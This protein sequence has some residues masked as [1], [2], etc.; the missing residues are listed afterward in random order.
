MNDDNA[1]VF[2]VACW[3]ASFWFTRGQEAAVQF[4]VGVAV[5]I[6]SGIL[7]NYL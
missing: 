1:L 3:L 7:Y 2:M 5:L 4:F 6:G